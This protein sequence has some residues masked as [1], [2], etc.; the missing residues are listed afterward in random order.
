MSDERDLRD[1]D[2][3][4]DVTRQEWATGPVG[5]D[6][7]WDGYGGA[8]SVDV[9]G[10]DVL[11]FD[12]VKDVPGL[13]GIPQAVSAGAK[14][15]GGDGDWS[16]LFNIA[17]SVGDLGVNVF[18][19]AVDPLN[20]LISA[21]L[22][23][24]VDVVQP[25]EDLLGLVTGNAE[26]MEG[27]IAKW[28][29]VGN[30]LDPLAA[31]IRA[32]VQEGLVGWQGLAADAARQR[33]DEFAQGVAGLGNDARKLVMTLNAAKLLMEVAQGFV[34]GLIAT[35][36]EWMVFTWTAAL[37]SAVP[38]MGASTAAAGAATT[39]QGAV[40]TTR[41]TTFISKVVA[42]LQRLRT[43][44]ARMHPKTM[45]SVKASFQLRGANG[46]FASGW[47][48]SSAVLVDS[49]KDFRTWLGPADK[50]AA[51]AANEGKRATDYFSDDA[52]LSDSRTEQ[53]L[54]PGR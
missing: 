10:Y 43:V 47:R 39:V 12:P 53:Y 40:V 52:E 27:E 45:A 32:A 49:A 48:G 23:F 11:R 36:V 5:A 16:E 6:T 41:A 3:T 38:T 24:L 44:L 42:L 9:G 33:M 34:L 7:T 50:F 37:A 28:E 20:F 18:A 51:T 14:L 54:D 31:E 8:G 4:N 35:F 30:A 46:T 26:R 25:L 15:A 29:R 19:Y 1:S 17:G 2:V 13:S 21:G 22:T